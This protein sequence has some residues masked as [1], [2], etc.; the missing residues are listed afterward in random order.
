MAI[1]E[2]SEKIH[3]ARNGAILGAYDSDK[4]ADLLENGQLLRTD[5]FFR[6]ATSEWILLAEFEAPTPNLVF[7]P[8]EPEN[9]DRPGKSRRGGKGRSKKSAESSLF[10]WVACLFALGAAAGIW[11]WAEY[12]NEQLKSSDEKVKSLTVQLENL[13]KEVQ[14]MN[15]ITPPGRVRGIIT[16]EPSANQVA[17][18]SGATVGLYHRGD[19]EAAI[20]KTQ[21]EGGGTIIS[22]EDFDQAIGRLKASIA[23]PIEITLTD[24]NGRID[25][26]VPQPGEYVLVASAAKTSSVGTERYFWLVGFQA[27]GQPSGLILLNERNAISQRKPSLKITDV[28]GFAGTPDQPAAP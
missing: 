13:R 25:L 12:L 7:R 20:A 17:I 15:E 21:T 9:P 4:I 1:P 3:V 26:A 16:Y 8:A 24:S 5:H 19:V 22:T 23:S 18:M 28:A 27:N 11:A 6:P 14:M 10:G 2:T